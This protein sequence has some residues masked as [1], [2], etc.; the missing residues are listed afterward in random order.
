[1]EKKNKFPDYIIEEL[2]PRF[3]GID[4]PTIAHVE[5]DFLDMNGNFIMY[6]TSNPDFDEL[7]FT[8]NSELNGSHEI[9]LCSDKMY[10]RIKKSYNDG[11]YAGY[12][13]VNGGLTT[14]RHTV[15]GES[16]YVTVAGFNEH[17]KIR[18]LREDFGIDIEPIYRFDASKFQTND[19]FKI[20]PGKTVNPVQYGILIKVRDKSLIFKLPSNPYGVDNKKYP[21]EY[22]CDI[23]WI[24]DGSVKLEHVVL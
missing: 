14:Y 10:N 18:A 24:L 6:K 1:M 9:T 8:I 15:T 4:T 3:R 7:R 12:D 16:T 5:C 17:F 22:I 23:K 20:I 11:T 21:Y 2:V 13:E 19:V